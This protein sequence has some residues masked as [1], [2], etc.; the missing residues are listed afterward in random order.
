MTK[1]NIVLVLIFCIFFSVMAISLWGKNPEG[2][3]SIVAESL[4][5]YDKNGAVITEEHSEEYHEKVLHLTKDGDHPQAISYDFSVDILPENT[6]DKALYYT[7]TIGSG[8]ITEVIKEDSYLPREKE[9]EEPKHSTHYHYHVVFEIEEQEMSK[10]EFTFNRLTQTKRDYL[11]FKW[12]E[13]HEQ[14]IPD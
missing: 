1:K 7:F 4:V 2:G 14:E 10:I 6:T 9:E 11:M 13:T 5:F 8:T 12:T 3:A